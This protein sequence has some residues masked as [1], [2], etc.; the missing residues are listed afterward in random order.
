MRRVRIYFPPQLAGAAL[1][2][3]DRFAS[4]GRSGNI[5][6][7]QRS[8]D[9][10]FSVFQFYF[11]FSNNKLDLSSRRRIGRCFQTKTISLSLSIEK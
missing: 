3:W 1:S 9:R 7:V 11:I 10:S 5:G 8:P 4:I 6:Q 2:V